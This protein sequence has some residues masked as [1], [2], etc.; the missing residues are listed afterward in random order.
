MNER[1]IAAARELCAHVKPAG[2]EEL[3]LFT[4]LRAAADALAA[5]PAAEPAPYP[6]LPEP[7]VHALLADCRGYL[8]SYAHA[9]IDLARE[10][11]HA[12]AAQ[13]AR[14]GG[15]AP[16]GRVTD[17]Q[18]VALK[19][20][21]G[22]TSSGRGIRELEQVK[23]F[24]H[25]IAAL[26]AA[27]QPAAAEQN[28]M[29][30]FAETSDWAKRT[31]RTITPDIVDLLHCLTVAANRWAEKM[32]QPAASTVPATD[33]PGSVAWRFDHLC[34]ALNQRF[35]HPAP[36][37]SVEAPE[38]HYLRAIDKMLAAAP[39]AAEREAQPLPQKVQHLVDTASKWASMSREQ[40]NLIGSGGVPSRRD[41]VL[42]WER[43]ES[44]HLA[45]LDLLYGIGSSK[46]G[47][48]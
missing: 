2:V 13:P 28:A 44:M 47:G 10:Q 42:L 34:N 21:F 48:E 38:K 11:G 31:G 15:D 6:T 40:D 16:A 1:L 17:E 3:V 43:Q 12:V 22:V 25:A 36:F 37:S 46:E 45:A 9:A 27:P 29:D 8:R 26:A 39:A 19:A 7:N 14:A 32:E 20:K 41:K 18:I 5:Q 33:I 35:P 4:E 23:D 24:A 30:L